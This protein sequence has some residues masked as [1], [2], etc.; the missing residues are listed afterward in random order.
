MKVFIKNEETDLVVNAL[1]ASSKDTKVGGSLRVQGQPG[2]NSE[3]QD[4]Q[5]CIERPFLKKRR[6]MRRRR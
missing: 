3:F 4:S 6:K 1:N 2:L 5:G